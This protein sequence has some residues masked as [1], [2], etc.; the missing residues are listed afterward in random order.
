MLVGADM[1]FSCFAKK[2]TKRRRL[3]GT[4]RKGTEIT[5]SAPF[6][7]F[8]YQPLRDSKNIV[9]VCDNQ[10]ISAFLSMA[11]NVLSNSGV[12]TFYIEAIEDNTTISFLFQPFTS[13]LSQVA[14][15]ILNPKLIFVEKVKRNTQNTETTQ[16]FTQN[17]QFMNDLL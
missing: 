8:Y 17:I 13:L 2:S 1:Y 14:L 15:T 4:F 9:G 5:A 3:K 16:L 10:G 11:G 7:T 12:G 6:G